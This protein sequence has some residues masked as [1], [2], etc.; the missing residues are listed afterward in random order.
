MCSSLG[1]S[2]LI[3][4]VCSCLGMLMLIIFVCSRLS[5][6]FWL[7]TFIFEKTMM[8]DDT[9]RNLVEVITWQGFTQ[10]HRLRTH[11]MYVIQTHCG[12]YIFARSEVS[13]RV[14]SHREFTV[15]KSVVKS[16]LTGVKPQSPSFLPT[17]LCTPIV[18]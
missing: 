14:Q 11:M 15:C 6:K 4:F 13:N 17:I 3:I 5:P 10:C 2:L 12:P 18:Q 8:Q 16:N 9:S 1:V 7:P